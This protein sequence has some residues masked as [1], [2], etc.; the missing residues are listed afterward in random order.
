MELYN[1]FKKNINNIDF[2]E[3]ILETTKNNITTKKD[4]QY[5]LNSVELLNRITTNEQSD[6]YY[7]NYDYLYPHLDDELLNIKISNLQEFKEHKY[8]VNIEKIKSIEE[9]AEKLCNSE[10]EL[11]PHQMFIKNFLS[12]YTPYNSLFLYHG[13]GTGKTCS[14][15]S[16]AEETR[17]FLKLNGYKERIIIVASRSVQTNFKLQLFDERKLKLE[18]GKY[19]ID[20]CAGNNFLK[21]IN[22][23]KS[24]VSREKVVKIVDNIINSY[25]LF[26]GYIEFAN[27]IIKKS[28]IDNVSFKALNSKEK[29]KLIKNKLQKFFGNRLI[30]I[31]EIHNIRESSS[32]ESSKLVAKQLSNL[33]KYVYNMKLVLMS[34]TPMYNDY[35]EI[36]YIANL[37][38][39]ND[40]RSSIEFSDVFNNDGTFVTDIE[41]NEVGKDLLKRK[42]NG[43]ISYVKGDNPFTFP[44]RILPSDYNKES[45]ITSID[46][47][48]YD[49]KK[50]RIDDKIRYFDLY[51]NNVN[52]YQEHVYNYIIYKTD[53]HSSTAFKYTELQKPLM[54]LNIVYPNSMLESSSF[55]DFPKLNINSEDLIAKNGLNSILTSSSDKTKYNYRFIDE[56]S[57][58]IFLK[59][60]IGKYSIKI[61]NILNA[62]E[63][64]EG[65]VIIYS[66]FIEAGLIPMALALECNGY[67]KFGN[68]S[69]FT[70]VESDVKQQFNYIMITGDKLLTDN[71][72]GELKAITDTNNVNGNIIKVVLLSMAGS[73]GIDFKFIRQIHI[74]EPWY[75]INRMEQII[76]RGIRNCSHKDLELVKRNCKIFMHT[77]LLENKTIETVD[78]L[79]YRKA[80]IKAIQIG[81]ITR[82]MKE[83]SVDC[84]LN[85]ELNNYNSDVLEKYNKSKLQQIL[86]NNEVIEFTIGDR[87]QT[88]LCD[89]M[90][91]CKYNCNNQEQYSEIEDTNSKSYNESFLETN[92]TSIINKIK[93]LF[94]EKYFY[95]KIEILSFLNNIKSYSIYSINNALTELVENSNYIIKD[96][97]G[98]IGKVINIDELYIFQPISNEYANSSMY[99]KI[100]PIEYN[101]DNLTFKVPDSIK[102]PI[103]KKMYANATIKI[104]DKFAVPNEDLYTTRQGNNN[105]IFSKLCEEYNNIMFNNTEYLKKFKSKNSHI[106]LLA[107]IIEKFKNFKSKNNLFDFSDKIELELEIDKTSKKINKKEVNKLIIQILI[108][109]FNFESHKSL[110]EYVF[111]D[112]I[113]VPY[114]E[115]IEKE[116]FIIIKEYYTKNMLINGNQKAFIFDPLIIDKKDIEDF[117]KDFNYRLFV[118]NNNK[119]LPGTPLNYSKDFVESINYNKIDLLTHSNTL[120]FIKIIELDNDDNMKYNYQFKIKEL[121]DSTKKNG[122]Y[123]SG[124]VCASHSQTDLKIIV[125][126]FNIKELPPKLQTKHLCLLV[127]IMLRYYNNIKKN[128]NNWFFNVKDSLI[129]KF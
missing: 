68:N 125:D 4:L 11:L 118:L 70:K 26:M 57:E 75:N 64:S 20:N 101:N 50:N 98:K 31:D 19:S 29:N 33:V 108:D 58:N 123:N 100:K 24:S 55:N 65:V 15:I 59:E 120:G 81:K 88:A 67:K 43:Y 128:G 2:D 79:L 103:D 114:V 76:G 69:L 111:D 90:E 30:I 9:E 39:L 28:N 102:K 3:S 51:L 116:L 32:D 74:M 129:N 72:K 113:E 36:I 18:N 80:E 77:S 16:I 23:L 86:S 105:L 17:E 89:Y 6:K 60:N 35:K 40:K 94:L 84:I 37:L 73:E 97:Y 46:Y 54:A 63:N 12:N 44:Y 121:K 127:E 62:I 82:L 47:P 83:T 117:T 34:A 87:P 66:Q 78:M 41:N 106:K 112:S 48:L 95:T 104:V 13:L 124:K 45:S 53:F 109:K 71:L 49:L 122:N 38:N 52:S 42:L 22:M 115:D 91:T 10:F 61:K 110:I 27:L 1:I 21:D 14:A 56:S 126:S 119:L 93:D 85:I 99:S 92:N 7:K 25:Y 8:N 5:F 107:E 96:K